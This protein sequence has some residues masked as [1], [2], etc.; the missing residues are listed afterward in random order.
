MLVLC[1]AVCHVLRSM[2][3]AAGMLSALTEHQPLVPPTPTNKKLGYF[4]TL[5][6]V[7]EG[8][9]GRERCVR[10]ISEDVPSEWALE[11]GL[12]GGV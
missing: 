7:Q 5:W 11:A 3:D 6:Q 9:P 4:S 1:Q 12:R 2:M 8:A 10:P